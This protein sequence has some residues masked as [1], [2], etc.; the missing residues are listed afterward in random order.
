MMGRIREV[1]AKVLG[2]SVAVW[3]EFLYVNYR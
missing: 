1:K 2:R 3:M